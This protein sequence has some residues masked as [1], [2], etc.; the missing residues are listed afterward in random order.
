MLLMTMR[1]IT[2]R[3]LSG[4]SLAHLVGLRLSETRG[5]KP[6]EK[7]YIPKL[8]SASQ[9]NG[10]RERSVQALHNTQKTRDVTLPGSMLFDA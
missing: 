4:Q 8:Y 7:R 2:S 6:E 3:K 5:R 9:F 1:Q 10:L